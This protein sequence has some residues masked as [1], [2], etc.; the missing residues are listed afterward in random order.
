MSSIKIT[1]GIYSVGI[2][3][4]NMRVFDIVMTT[5]SGTS[6]NSYI[7]KGQ[8]KTAL[9]ETCHLDFFDLYLENIREVCDPSEISYIILNHNEP[10]HSGALAKVMEVMPQA[11]IVASQ[12]GALY[13]KN[14]TNNPNLD[15]MK[16]KDGD[17]IDL[18]GRTLSFISAPFLHWPD[19]MF[20]WVEEAKTLFTCDF[21]GCH[22]CEPYTLDKYIAY[23]K[24]Y[25][26]ALKLYYDAIFG[27][28]GSYV[29]KGLEKVA[30][31]GDAPE[32]IC[33][34]HGPILTKGHKLEHVIQSYEKWSAPFSNPVPTIPVFYC[35]AYGNTKKIAESI[36]EGILSVLP[37]A[38]VDTYDLIE[39]D[40]GSLQEK[41]N[42]SDAFAIGTPTLNRDAVP[43]V[44]ILLS[45]IDAVN[46]VKKPCLVFGSF[47][48]SGEA[49]PNVKAR[50]ESLKM[51]VF[52]DGFKVTFVPTEE[53]LFQ[54][55]QL[56]SEFAKSFS[57]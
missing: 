17:T 14:I 52:G 41:L 25:E 54:A 45:G 56:G 13:L 39:H 43:P 1:D 6:Y 40:M 32:F 37:N 3:N 38:C 5:D 50:L 27:P 47:G 46:S 44:W 22:Y 24:A 23:D 12:A 31:L 16:V 35:T 7:V 19:S 8:D 48:W 4:P 18:G 20:T 29:K 9:I 49:V 33:T 42:H 51:N 15:V 21:F 57:K 55:K 34:S 26:T 11:K 30:A 53:D 10:D 36:R 28:F 2:N